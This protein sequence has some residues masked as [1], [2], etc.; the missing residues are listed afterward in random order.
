MNSAATAESSDIAS[1][2]FDTPGVVPLKPSKPRFNFEGPTPIAED[3]D[4]IKL[5][6]DHRSVTGCKVEETQAP[7][8]AAPFS[9]Q[10]P[11][12]KRTYSDSTGGVSDDSS[13][14]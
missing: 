11:V 10:L 2:P 8:E 1:P 9:V 5:N 3:A 4:L 6:G 13:P 12:L 7:D 14:V